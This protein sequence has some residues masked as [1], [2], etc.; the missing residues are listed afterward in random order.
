MVETALM[1]P[2]LLLFFSGMV[3][4]VFIARSY[5]AILD[6]TYQGAHLG[7]QGLVLFDNNEIY[8]LVLQDL[9]QEGYNNNSLIDVI[10]TRA[11]L[12]GGKNLL[13]YQVYHMK[14]SNRPSILTQAILTNRLDVNDPP[15]RLIAVEVVYDK[16]LLFG[17]AFLKDLIPNPFPLVAYTIQ[18]VAR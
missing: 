10:I 11:D 2:I 12:P 13:N 6:G 7:S 16:Q 1:F 8:T 15:G 18:Y 17:W 9:S 5:L 14:G 3:E 4:V